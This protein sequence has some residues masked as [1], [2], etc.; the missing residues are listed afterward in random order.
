MKFA[1]RC[2]PKWPYPCCVDCAQFYKNADPK[3][4]A[5]IPLD[6]RDYSQDL[7]GGQLQEC[8]M[9]IE[10]VGEGCAQPPFDP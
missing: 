9:Y 2:H 10:K 8:G 3:D 5:E 7:K 4:Y 1:A 6:I